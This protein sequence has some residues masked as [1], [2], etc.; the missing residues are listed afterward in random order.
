MGNL[1][2]DEDMIEPSKYTEA[3]LASLQSLDSNDSSRAVVWACYLRCLVIDMAEEIDSLRKERTA[4]EDNPYADVEKALKAE[5]EAKEFRLTDEAVEW[6]CDDMAGKVEEALAQD[7]IQPDAYTPPEPFKPVFGLRVKSKEERAEG[8]SD[9]D[10]EDYVLRSEIREMIKE[11]IGVII[12]GLKGDKGDVGAD[13]M[14]GEK[15]EKGDKGDK[16]DAGSDGRGL[17]IRPRI[18]RGASGG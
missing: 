1:I 18:H 15:G 10:A 5:E 3:L 9:D 13:G 16:G 12:P 11:E 17:K 2:G 14:T 8:E 4:I 6:L 7:N